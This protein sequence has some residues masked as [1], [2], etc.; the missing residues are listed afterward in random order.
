MSPAVVLIGATG[1][2]KSATANT[3]FSNRTNDLFP[4]SN[5]LSS[6]TFQASCKTLAWRGKNDVITIVD[7]P[8]LGDTTGNDLNNFQ[9]MVSLL[10]SDVKVVNAFLRIFNGQDPRSNEQ[11]KA[12]VNV[13][14]K[15]FMGEQFIQNLMVG[16]TRWENDKCTQRIRR[17]TGE[18]I[19]SKI[20]DINKLLC[21]IR[22]YSPRPMFFY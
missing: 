8:G 3:L 7:T 20:D 5:K 14:K 21:G 2:G 15:M 10:K 11:V 22:D 19:D 1:S 12:V 17:N 6:K 18:S 9:Q 13:F 16:I 4:T